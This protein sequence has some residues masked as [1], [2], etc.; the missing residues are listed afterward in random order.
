MNDGGQGGL[1]VRQLCVEEGGHHGGGDVPGLGEG[2]HI[3]CVNI[4]IVDDDKDSTVTTVAE[5]NL[6]D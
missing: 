3:Q 4:K 1:Q 2:R 5:N 6:P